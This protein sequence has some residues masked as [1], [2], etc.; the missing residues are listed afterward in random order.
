MWPCS[1]L[2]KPDND[3][4]CSYQVKASAA[5]LGEVKADLAIAKAGLESMVA[6]EAAATAQKL[7]PGGELTKLTERFL[8]RTYYMQYSVPHIQ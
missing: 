4:L 5:V 7:G 3:L 8:P 1:L 6:K 2:V